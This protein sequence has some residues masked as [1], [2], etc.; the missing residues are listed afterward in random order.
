M[1][2]SSLQA[3]LRSYRDASSRASGDIAAETFAISA[4]DAQL[5]GKNAQLLQ[6][7]G[8]LCQCEGLREKCEAL[9][10]AAENLGAMVA[11]ALIEEGAKTAAT[12]L[13]SGNA[14]LV[15]QAISGASSVVSA[16]QGDIDALNSRRASA[17]ERREKAQARKDAAER[18]IARTR[19]AISSTPRS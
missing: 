19:W 12:S 10:S 2:I 11:S 6:A 1:S 18:N 13:T 4:I 14:S 9:D 3:E 7:K 5:L 15:E 16:L 8:A 17:I